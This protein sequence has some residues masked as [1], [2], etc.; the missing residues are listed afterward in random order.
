MG[1]FLAC[2]GFSKKR[3][4]RI[5]AHRIVVGGQIKGSYE[6]LDSSSPIISLGKAENPT[7][8]DSEPRQKPKEQP[9]LKPRKKVSFNLN[10]QT[11]EPIS[12]TY[13]LL[14]GEEEEQ[15]GNNGGQESTAYSN[16]RYQ[17]CRDCYDEEDDIAFEDG[18][19]DEEEDDDD[20][21]DDDE[22]DWES[23][24]VGQR[25]SQEGLSKQLCKP[26]E[27]N[28]NIN[29]MP[30]SVREVHSVL[31]PVENLSQWRAA[32]AKAAPQKH[33]RKENIGVL[34]EPSLPFKSNSNL[35]SSP[36]CNQSK[37]ILQ[38]IKVDASLSS[39]LNSPNVH[40][41]GVFNAVEVRFSLLFQA[42][43]FG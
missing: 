10:V 31:S 32:K 37:P 33:Q 6:P 24:I 30:L 17:N 40:Q 26:V 34:Q 3:K 14:E 42:S 28:A 36:L 27:E 22:Y 9:K 20:D 29:A 8:A 38:E 19:F 11:Y 35:N 1:C 13:Y 15:M 16:Y 2:F 43:L 25:I 41:S 18:D 5:P 21:D 39:W 7:S 4:R 12:N 23:D